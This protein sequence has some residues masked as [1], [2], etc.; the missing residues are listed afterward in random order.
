MFWRKK[1]PKE[2]DCFVEWYQKEYGKYASSLAELRAE[3]NLDAFDV[4][5]DDF[6]SGRYSSTNW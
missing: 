3:L 2:L 4:S 1:C 5:F 6:E